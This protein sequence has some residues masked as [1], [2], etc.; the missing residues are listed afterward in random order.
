MLKKTRICAL[1]CLVL[2]TSFVSSTVTGVHATQVIGTITVGDTPGCMA[3]DSGKGEIFV[4]NA[5][6]NTI[7]VI[8][9][10][11]NKVIATIPVGDYPAA[12][13]YDSGKG[14]IF[15]ATGLSSH[16]IQV[17]SDDTNQIIATIPTS[18]HAADLAYDS[19]KGEIFAA[20]G[21]GTPENFDHTYSYDGQY[22]ISVYAASTNN[23]WS[24]AGYHTVDVG[25]VTFQTQV[26]VFWTT[27]GYNFYPYTSYQIYEPAGWNYLDFGSDFVLSYNYY[28]TSYHTTN[29]DWYNLGTGT[30]IDVAYWW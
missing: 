5:L 3:Y 28:T 30:Q 15:V 1:F 17:I 12:M 2:I 6:S 24:N 9:D 10:T 20:D 4:G 16:E 7:S 22:T 11:T 21:N 27:D 29:P 19:A 26:N 25:T 23:V 13:A 18:W 8:S 14:E